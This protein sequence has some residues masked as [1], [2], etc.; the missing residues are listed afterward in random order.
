MRRTVKCGRRIVK[1]R[2]GGDVPVMV[3]TLLPVCEGGAMRAAGLR[4]RK[5]DGTHD[6][7][8]HAG[9]QR[10]EF[11]VR[12]LQRKAMLVLAAPWIW[13]KSR[14]GNAVVAFNRFCMPL[15]R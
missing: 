11:P 14:N 7:F 12:T 4:A 5:F 10:E 6:R 3:A 2:I 13:A 8:A 15:L 9:R 1:Y